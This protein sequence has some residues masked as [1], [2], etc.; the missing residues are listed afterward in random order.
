MMDNMDNMMATCLL[1]FAPQV[2]NKPWQSLELWSPARVSLSSLSVL[3]VAIP[4]QHRDISMPD[5]GLRRR[6][7]SPSCASAQSRGRTRRC[8]GLSGTSWAACRV[9]VAEGGMCVSVV[10][11]S[12]DV[13]T[14]SRFVCVNLAQGLGANLPH[15]SNF[16]FIRTLPCPPLPLNSPAIIQHPPLP[17]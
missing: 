11:G 14:V 8:A 3:V 10:G 17:P 13:G 2:V 15:C 7:C 6:R 5:G 9:A 16:I 1:G 12:K 4:G